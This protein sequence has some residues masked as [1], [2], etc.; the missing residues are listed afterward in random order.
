M[1]ICPYFRNS[2]RI[3]LINWIIMPK[4]A[5]K[6]AFGKGDFTKTFGR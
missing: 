6:R 4:D 3:G 1:F 2:L 5:F